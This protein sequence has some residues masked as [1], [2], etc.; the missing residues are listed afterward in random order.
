MFPVCYFSLHDVANGL[1]HPQTAEQV[2]GLLLV[3]WLGHVPCSNIHL[4]SSE[5]FQVAKEDYHNQIHV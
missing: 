5:E 1:Q 3:C 2:H 4:K